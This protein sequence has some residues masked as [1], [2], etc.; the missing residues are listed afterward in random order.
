M[1]SVRCVRAMC[2]GIVKWID[3]LQQLD[4]RAGP[5]GDRGS[6]GSPKCHPH[7]YLAQRPSMMSFPLPMPTA[8]TRSESPACRSD[9]ALTRVR[10][11]DSFVPIFAPANE[12]PMTRREFIAQGSR[13]GAGLMISPAFVLASSTTAASPL[14]ASAIRKLSGKLHGGL[15]LPDDQSYDSARRIFSWNPT[16]EKRPALIVRCADADDVAESIEFARMNDLEVAVRGGGHDVLGASVCDGMVIDLSQMKNIEVHAASH[17]ARVEAGSRSGEL[18]TATEKHGLAAVLGCNPAVG[19]AGLTLGGG[20]GWML[21][22]H[23]AACD[24]LRSLRLVTAD[25]RRLSASVHENSDLFWAL[26]GGGGNFGVVIDFEYELHPQGDIVGGFLLYPGSEA[27]R[28]YRFYRDF[29][30]DA[31]DELAI[32]TTFDPRGITVM[33]CFSGDPGRGHEVLRPLHEF[34]APLRGE[35]VTMPYLGLQGPPP[36]PSAASAG[37]LRQSQH[38][39]PYQMPQFIY[40]KGAYLRSLTDAAID[41]IIHASNDA[42]AGWS[43]GLGHY[44]HGAACRVGTNDTPLYREAGGCCCF[45]NQ[46][47]NDPSRAKDAMKWV[48]EVWQ[49]L[50]PMSGGHA[51]VNYLSNDSRG[52]VQS[53]YGANYARLLTLKTKY[54]PD[55]FFH[56]NRNIQPNS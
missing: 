53:A 26:R 46:G 25:G 29:M 15:I 19:I 7:R 18:N 47:W 34:G 3:D 10:G 38:P 28:F 22:K 23:G 32:E 24:N 51:Y 20:L 35:I 8:Y 39:S 48:N 54:D 14:A 41:T 37:S 1:E 12:I 5:I 31:P 40:W 55:N 16:T 43:V 9:Y 56:L 17:T 36:H 50:T 49:N 27:R 13:I 30:N 33:I 6:D 52:G 2:R 42:P 11:G 21:G 44:M 45:V 4:D